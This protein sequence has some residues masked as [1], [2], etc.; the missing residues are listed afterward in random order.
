MVRRYLCLKI[1]LI[2]IVMDIA[3]IMRNLKDELV[4]LQAPPI[5][6]LEG[7]SSLYIFWTGRFEC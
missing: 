1:A 3:R 5:M 6:V 7:E 4:W 2:I